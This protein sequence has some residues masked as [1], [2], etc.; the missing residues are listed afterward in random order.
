[1]ILENIKKYISNKNLKLDQNLLQK[2]WKYYEEHL[3]RYTW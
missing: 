2:T 3:P 1:M